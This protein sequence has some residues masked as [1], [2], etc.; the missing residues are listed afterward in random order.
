V[1]SWQ[2]RQ[3]R[4]AGGIGQMSE[5]KTKEAVITQADIEAAITNNVADILKIQADRGDGLKWDKNA[6]ISLIVRLAI[7]SGLP[8]DARKDFALM[9]AESGVGGN[10]S[11]FLQSK[12]LKDKL[13]KT[14]TRKQMV[15][16]Y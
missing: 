4:E 5:N 6:H 3:S 2:S 7:D 8:E 11:Q 9:L 13:P 16:A 12:Y 10:Q 15:E 1:P 14:A